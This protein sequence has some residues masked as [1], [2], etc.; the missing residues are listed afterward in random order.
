MIMITMDTELLEMLNHLKT[1]QITKM[2]E[3]DIPTQIANILDQKEINLES[4]YLNNNNLEKYKQKNISE[5]CCKCNRPP[6]Y[7]ELNNNK[8]FCWTHSME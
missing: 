8:L 4:N 5:K 7:I 6:K 3:I 1:I 2:K